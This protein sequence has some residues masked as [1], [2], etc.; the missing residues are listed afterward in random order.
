[1]RL[2]NLLS[3]LRNTTKPTEKQAVLLR[4]DSR[5]L[6]ELLRYTYD[7]FILFNVNIIAKDVPAPAD[8]DLGEIFDDVTMLMNFCQNS[9]SPKQNRERVNKLLGQ[10]NAGS[11]ELLM[12]TL[13][14]NWKAGISSKTVLKV[15]PGLISQFSVQLSE[16]YDPNKASHKR[17]AYGLSYKLDGLRCVALRDKKTPTWKLY[18]RKGKEFLTVD[19]LKPQLEALYRASGWTFFDGELYKHGLK[20]EEIQGPVMAFTKGQV[21]HM[22]YHVFA[23]GYA[24]KFLAGTEPEHVIIPWHS[25]IDNNS[26]I[27][28]VE[29][30]LIPP[31]HIE[32]CLETAFEKGYE[33]IMLRDPEMPYDYKRSSA[34]LKLKSRLN[35]EDGEEGEVI[36]DCV[37]I[38]IEYNDEFPVVENGEMKTERLLNR[39]IVEQASVG[40]ETIIC[41]VGSGFDL[42]FRRYFTEHPDELTSKVVEIK[43]QGWGANGR[44]RFPRLWRVRLD[45]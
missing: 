3:E 22:E 39:L 36:S 25:D 11:Q 14:K 1:M 38:D 19:H 23:V 40:E 31:E 17:Q 44:M 41:K 15:F 21:P 27:K 28:F 42:D 30:G 29:R 37:V 26:K 20:F 4:Y 6:R 10:L 43:H 24:D 2:E 16:T 34:L 33:G 18:S 45:L 13:N 35:T 8:H 5:Q 12:L 7:P 9:K 32:E